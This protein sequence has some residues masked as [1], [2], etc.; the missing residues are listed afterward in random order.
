MSETTEIDLQSIEISFGEK[1]IQFFGDYESFELNYSEI[2][3]AHISHK[4]SRLRMP[5]GY[6]LNVLTN[7][8]DQFVFVFQARSIFSSKA[9]LE[10]RDKFL[11]LCKAVIEKSCKYDVTMMLGSPTNHYLWKIFLVLGVISAL[12][13]LSAPILLPEHPTVFRV[14]LGIFCSFLAMKNARDGLKRNWAFER[15][16]NRG[17]SNSVKAL[18]CIP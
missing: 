13:F 4:F 16:L 7:T 5:I 15:K 1:S 3:K 14:S 10:L 12:F 8:S 9:H 2:E 17:S 6:K 11:S 18:D